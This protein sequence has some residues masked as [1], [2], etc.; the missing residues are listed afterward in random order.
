MPDKL[1]P[2]ETAKVQKGSEYNSAE[3][4]PVDLRASWAYESTNSE[5]AKVEARLDAIVIAA[6][7]ADDTLPAS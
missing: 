5:E 4:V 1:T 6:E 3:G 7:V 2:E